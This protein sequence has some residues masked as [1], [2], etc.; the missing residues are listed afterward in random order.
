MYVPCVVYMCS[1]SYYGLRMCI[2]SVCRR[3]ICRR[4]RRGVL[5]RRSIRHRIHHCRII[6]CVSSISISSKTMSSIDII[7]SINMC[8][9]FRF[10]HRCIRRMSHIRICHPL[11]HMH[12]RRTMSR[13][14]R[15]IVCVFHRRGMSARRRL[16]RRHIRRIRRRNV[17]RIR[18]R[19]INRRRSSVYSRIHMYSSM[20]RRCLRCRLRSINMCLRIRCIRVRRRIRRRIRI[21]YELRRHRSIRFHLIRRIRIQCRRR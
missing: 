19:R 12:S 1:S 16:R 11:R 8:V 17:R 4:R 6:C 21:T 9:W 7:S 15:R 3:R 18:R 14:R 5:R 20:H 13:R 10:P 2:R